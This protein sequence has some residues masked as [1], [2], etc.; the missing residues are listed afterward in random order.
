MQRTPRP[1]RFQISDDEVSASSLSVPLIFRD[2]LTSYLTTNV[3][4]MGVEID[5]GPRETKCFSP[6]QSKRQGECEQRF[7]AVPS[8]RVKQPLRLINGQRPP[9]RLIYARWIGERGNIAHQQP[10]PLGLVKR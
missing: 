6:P 2:A 3:N 5:V 1:L 7:E 8:S 10:L 9:L 4:Q